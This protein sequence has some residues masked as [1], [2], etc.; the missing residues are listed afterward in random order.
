VDAVLD[1]ADE[2]Q[3]AAVGAGPEVKSTRQTTETFSRDELRKYFERNSSRLRCA[4]EKLRA[5]SS[6][7][8][9]RF[10]ETAK[11]LEEALPLLDVPGSLDLEDV[12]RR[13]TVLEAKLTA[14]LTSDA[15][16]EILLAIRREMD[17]S[18]APYRR[19]MSVEQLAQLE[20]QYLQK[21]LFEHFGVPR[22]SLF[23]LT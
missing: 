7:L 12:E 14:A 8:A 10:E 5:N 21:R 19:K 17:R 16:E 1:A 3:E 15:E 18:L 23:Y 22:L 13:V 2:A 4:A 9:A 20:R 6:A 11:R